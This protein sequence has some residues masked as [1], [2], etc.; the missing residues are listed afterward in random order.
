MTHNSQPNSA[1][2]VPLKA[3]PVPRYGNGIHPPLTQN[4][5]LKTHNS[6]LHG[7]RIAV[8]GYSFIENSDDARHTP[9][10][11]FLQELEKR[12]ATYSIHDPYVKETE[13]DFLIEQDLDKALKGCDAVVL[14]T[15]HDEYKSISPETLKGLLT[16]AVAVDGRNLFDP[17]LFISAGFIFKGVGKG[18]INKLI[19]ES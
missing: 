10:V 9:T 16:G 4:S 14:M 19:A 15:K 12:G 6:P 17:G 3:C 1:E 8:L 5:L 7:L 13:E 18:S 2:F 11:P